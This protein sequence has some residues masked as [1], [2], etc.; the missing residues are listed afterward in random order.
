MK[1]LFVHFISLTL[2]ITS[3]TQ[4]RFPQ[5]IW[6]RIGSISCTL[7]IL[8]VD[9]E[10]FFEDLYNFPSLIMLQNVFAHCC[11]FICNAVFLSYPILAIFIG[12]D[13]SEWSCLKNTGVNEWG[14]KR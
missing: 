11:S 9:Q 8:E 12:F 3:R 5:T 7:L 6:K 13:I 14:R 4:L 1:F 2:T 10:N